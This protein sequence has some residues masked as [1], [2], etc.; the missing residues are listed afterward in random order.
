M[1]KGR[2]LKAAWTLAGLCI[3]AS[4]AAAWAQSAIERYPVPV[5]P[6]EKA[7]LIIDE[8]TYGSDD[9]KPFG[10]DLAGVTLIGENAAALARPEPGIRVAAA[11]SPAGRDDIPAAL[12]AALK[13]H[14]GMPL[15]HAAI[16]E[17]QAAVAGVYRAEGLPFVSV[18]TPPQE[19][20]SGVVQLRV[21]V[22]RLGR[23]SVEGAGSDKSAIGDSVRVRPGEAIDANALSED[24]DWL[25]RNPYRAVTGVFSQGE[26][27]TLSDLTLSVSEGKPWSVTAGWSNT[28]S[29]STGRQRYSVGGGFWLPSA[30]GATVSYLLTGSGDAFSH[31]GRI[32][33][34]DG[35]FPHYVSHAARVVVPTAARQQI[36]FTPDL[37][38]SRIDIDAYTA[39]RSRTFELPLVYRTAVSNLL[40]GKYW[41]EIYG[42]IAY[43]SAQR[44]VYFAGT[45]AASGHA[46]LLQ[47][48]AGWADTFR[49]RTGQTA[50]DVQLV[51]NPGKTVAGSDD[52]SWS[53][54][55][56]GRVSSAS[57]AYGIVS[58]TR[59]TKLGDGFAWD[60]EFTG[61][62]AGT[63]LPDTE[64]LALGGIAGSRGYGFYDASA[65]R[66]VIWRNTVR[67]AGQELPAGMLPWN[68]SIS[69]YV[70]ADVAWG[71]DLA[72]QDSSTLLSA[73]A[74]FDLAIANHVT[75]AFTAGRAITDRT[76]TRASAWN[77]MANVSMTF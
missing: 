49:G 5:A 55:S 75:G 46:A 51:G 48:T 11:P 52:Q 58:L 24:I 76:A 37:V 29:A 17:L 16:A 19:V 27:T 54:F 7:P 9:T 73:G 40:P 4:P 33:L 39:V 47:V 38:A 63:P 26:A 14:L 28:G 35:A 6:P 23:A 70:F 44:Q 13:P 68:G 20:T 71:E 74:G 65:D 22:F 45:Q 32:V 18:T 50:V 8:K 3:A 69:P 43:K 60:S 15:S 12:E 21:I 31:P 2:N 64:R 67:L 42:G 62:L 10:V 59:R 66:G 25:N 1:K 30:G 72:A 34:Q 56:G 41:G 77:I 57:Y 53:I 61:M 36:E